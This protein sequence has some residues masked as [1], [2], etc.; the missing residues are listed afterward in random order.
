[1][2]IFLDSA[3]TDSA[4]GRIFPLLQCAVGIDERGIQRLFDSLRMGLTSAG[5]YRHLASGRK[6]DPINPAMLK[7]FLLDL[8]ALQNG[9]SVA[10]ELLYMKFASLQEAK[11]SIPQDLVGCAC[12]LLFAV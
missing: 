4:L 3:I 1:M 10:I 7:R 9:I 2:A 8:S 11:A 5:M 12:E 6:T